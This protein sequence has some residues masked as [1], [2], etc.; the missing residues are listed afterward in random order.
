MKRVQTGPIATVDQAGATW[1][2]EPVRVTL[3]NVHWGECLCITSD[4]NWVMTSGNCWKKDSCWWTVEYA[5]SQEDG[6]VMFKNLLHN[7]FVH[8]L[9]T[10]A[11]NMDRIS[12]YDST[13]EGSQWTV[14]AVDDSPG[15]FKFK[16][17]RSGFFMHQK[18]D[19]GGKAVFLS[20]SAGE[21]SQWIAEVGK[22]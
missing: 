9:S 20:P 4:G 14:Q 12:L 6:I 15:K 1:T 5:G 11:K 2:L 10:R 3:K 8:V 7:K 16:N 22:G 19:G 13:S 18:Y 17:V 21:S